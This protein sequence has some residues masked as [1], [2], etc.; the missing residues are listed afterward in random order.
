[1]NDRAFRKPSSR[2]AVKAPVQGEQK[3]PAASEAMIR[4]QEKTGFA[5]K[6]LADEKEDVWNDL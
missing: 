1:M 4:L 3:M 2:A 5:E 6:I